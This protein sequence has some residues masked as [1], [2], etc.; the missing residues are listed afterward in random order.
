[1]MMEDKEHWCEI[2]GYAP[3]EASSHGRIRSWNNGRYGRRTRPLIMKQSWSSNGY[4]CINIGQKPRRVHRLLALAFIPNPDNKYCVDH[5]DG[6]IL[7]NSLNNLRWATKAENAY[8]SKV[9]CNNS[10]G[11]RGVGWSKIHKRWYAFLRVGGEQHQKWCSSKEEAIQQRH[12]LENQFI[13]EFV[14]QT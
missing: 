7:N 14:R 3:Y 12:E 8:N 2:P 5:I 1:M 10:T 6:D 4:M 11:H 13:S 9:Q